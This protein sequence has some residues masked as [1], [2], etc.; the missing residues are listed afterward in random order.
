MSE[1]DLPGDQEI[2]LRE[3]HEFG[4]RSVDELVQG[5]V[6]LTDEF[7]APK[8]EAVLTELEALGLTENTSQRWQLTSAGTEKAHALG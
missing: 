1:S 3:L 8:I 2:M 5:S 4:P 7:E 6:F